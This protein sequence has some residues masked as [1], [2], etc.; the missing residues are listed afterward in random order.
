MSKPR[1]SFLS[2]DE[3]NT[4]HNASLEVLENTGIRVTDEAVLDI[5]KK[6]GAGVDYVKKHVTIP[7][8]LVEEALRR[9]PKTTTYAARNP[10]YDVVLNKQ[11]A[12]FWAEGGA[13]FIVDRETGER[14]YSRLEDSA[15]WAVLADYLDHF[16]FLWPVGQATNVPS[17]MRGIVGMCTAL[18][19]TEKHVGVGASSAQA[20]QYQIE[21]A[22]AIVGGREQLR[23]RPII[24]AN[25]CPISPLSYEDEMTDAI[26][27]YAKAGLP[28]L[29]W[30]MP[31][32]GET[33]P[34]TL[35]GTMVINN[36]EVLGGLTALEFA[37]PGVPVV[38]TAGVGTVDFKTGSGIISPEGTL[39]NLAL[40]QLAYHYDLPM[41]VGSSGSASK[42]LDLQ[43]GYDD[44]ISLL[45][46]MLIVPDMVMGF[47]SLDSA[48]TSSM[49]ALVIDNE[50]IDY[51][52][53][54]TQ[55]FEVN[56]ETL[57]VDVI[58]KVGPGGIFLGEK[59]TLQH[60]KE[61]WPSR[62]SDIDSFE[63]WQKKGSKSIGEVAH[64]KVKEILATHKPEP[65]AEDVEKEIAQILKRATAEL[66]D[67]D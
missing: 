49:E 63:A 38:Y 9:A 62:L 15:Q 28:I 65:I 17:G 56:D 18:R 26:I 57:A 11:K 48:L 10:E 25:V 66:K 31:L 16:H 33:S 13:P 40:A 21:I 24:S 23:K 59:H 34:A 8:G 64:E 14:R 53:R 42:T 4:I 55:G 7:R 37:S 50:I 46:H 5:L 1:I 20:A 54:Y 39:M 61:R 45:A 47:G 43:A 60:F 6:T 44:A 51:A 19:N 41:Q 2:E 32:M 27:E 22:A 3:L 35:S 52:L 29:M 12:H 67:D 36:A 30:P 58:D